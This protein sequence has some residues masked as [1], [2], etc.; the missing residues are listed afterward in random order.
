MQ[1]Q[2]HCYTYFFHD[3]NDDGELLIVR[4]LSLC[5]DLRIADEQ[6]GICN[7]ALYYKE[8]TARDRFDEIIYMTEF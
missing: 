2:G 3:W 1:S 6:T 5:S 7:S 4:K 8:S